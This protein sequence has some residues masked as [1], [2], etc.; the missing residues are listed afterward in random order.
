[1]RYIA[2]SPRCSVLWRAPEP[3]VF[4]KDLIVVDDRLFH[5]LNLV[6]LDV[7]VELLDRFQHEGLGLFLAML[8]LGQLKEDSAPREQGV[9]EPLLQRPEAVA[10]F[11]QGTAELH[12][13]GLPLTTHRF[14]VVHLDGDVLDALAIL[15]DELVDL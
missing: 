14:D 10:A 8:A 15:L 6:T 5:A 3:H 11:L 13:V 7:L 2:A 9:R 12:P 4:A 1:M